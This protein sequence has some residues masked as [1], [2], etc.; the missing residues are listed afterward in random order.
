MSSRRE[1]FPFVVR[2][3]AAGPASLAP[4]L[5]LRLRLGDREEAAP[6]L[7]DTGAAVNV[8][9]WSVGERLGG[10]WASAPSVTLT[11]NLAAVEARVLVC[12]GLVGGFRARRMAF[13]WSR[14]DTVPVLL[15]Q[16]NFLLA[17]DVCLSRSGQWFEVAEPGE[18]T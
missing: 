1:R 3:P 6:G 5:Q 16:V 7:I 11:G 10:D 15:G 12:E 2:D 4:V 8:L 14:S 13:A 18:A 17:F 9:P